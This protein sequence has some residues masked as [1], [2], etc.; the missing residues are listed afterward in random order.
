M[1]IRPL[2]ATPPG[3]PTSLP[4]VWGAIIVVGAL[5]VLTAGLTISEIWRAR[6]LRRRVP[7]STVWTVQVR[8][9]T[10]FLVVSD[11]E[12]AILSGSGGGSRWPITDVRAAAP[13]TV[14]FS[15]R[16]GLAVEIGSMN[17]RERYE[18]TFPRFAGFG[19]SRARA[20][21]AARTIWSARDRAEYS[22]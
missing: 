1:S 12:I 11:A 22:N 5:F 3:Q 7:G 18:M 8:R 16:S 14:H 9:R 15:R 2:L 17:H 13:A 4:F 21:A 19:A 6:A 20:D 10:R